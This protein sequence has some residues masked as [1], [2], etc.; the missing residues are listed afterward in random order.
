MKKKEKKEWE[1]SWKGRKREKEKVKQP[2]EKRHPEKKLLEQRKKKK[3]E[4]GHCWHMVEFSEI[5]IF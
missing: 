2:A 5:N 4:V 3:T 1:K